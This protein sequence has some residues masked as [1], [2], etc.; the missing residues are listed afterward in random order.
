MYGERVYCTLVPILW[1]GVYTGLR[2][3]RVGVG[4]PLGAWHA[5]GGTWPCRYLGISRRGERTR[6]G[7]RL[8][9]PG[10]RETRLASSA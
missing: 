10:G 3:V 7:L 4:R 5:V 9:S 6:R 8:P 1:Y 2:P